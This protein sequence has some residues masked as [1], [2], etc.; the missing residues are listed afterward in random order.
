MAQG[1]NDAIINY[2]LDTVWVLT[3]QLREIGIDP[4]LGGISQKVATKSPGPARHFGC[5][6]RAR[7]PRQVGHPRRAGYPRHGGPAYQAGLP[8]RG[9][10]RG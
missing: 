5:P 7:H 10:S 4:N 6:R 2:L 1:K 3:G 9:Q 8:Y